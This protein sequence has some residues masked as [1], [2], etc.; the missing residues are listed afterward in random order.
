MEHEYNTVEEALEDLKQG[1]IVLVTDDENRENEGDMICAAEFATQEN[2]N[3]MAS[4]A[5]GLICTP[6]S[7]ELAEKL[8]MMG[9]E[10]VVITGIVQ[11]TFISNYCYEREKEGKKGYFVKALKIGAQRSGTGDIFTS[12]IAADA[13]NGVDF[14][15]SVKKASSFIKKCIM[16]SIELDIPLTDGVCFEELLYSL[17]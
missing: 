8:S 16:K 14:H 10:K 12:I 3:F 11:G 9:P 2:I 4:Y 15:K 5:K 1:K 13:V 6:M 17:K 7:V